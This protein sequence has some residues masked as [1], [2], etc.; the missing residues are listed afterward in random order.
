M[1]G[2]RSVIFE[3][4]QILV[5]LA[6]VFASVGFLFLHA[7]GTRIRCGG[8]GVENGKCPVGIVVKLLIGVAMLGGLLKTRG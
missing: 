5:S 7:N 2:M 4:I 8:F 1:R 3:T 6:T